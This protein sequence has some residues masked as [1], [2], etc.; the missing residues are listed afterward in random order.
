[1][2]M[3]WNIDAHTGNIVKLKFFFITQT[4]DLVKIYNTHKTNLCVEKIIININQLA[5]C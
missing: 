4:L 5:C 1:M 3:D 2:D